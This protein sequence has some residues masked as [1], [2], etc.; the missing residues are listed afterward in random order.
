MMS[1]A[2]PQSP[3]QALQRAAFSVGAL[4]LLLS[5]IGAFLSPERFFPSYLYAWLFAL[6]ITLGSTTLMA[7]HTLVGGLWGLL[8]R[9]WLDA[10]SRAMPLMVLLGLP[11]LFGLPEIF[12]WM[13]GFSRPE[14]AHQAAYLNLPFFLA[15]QALYVLVWLGLSRR[16]RQVL[17]AQEEAPT[18]EGAWRGQKQGALWL[19]CA[20]VTVTFAGIDWVVSLES[21][22]NSSI[23]GFIWMAGQLLAG[24]AAA[25]AGFCWLAPRTPLIR[26]HHLPLRLIDM[27]N[28]LLTAVMV[29]A[30]VAFS[31]LL[32]IW[33]GNLPDEVVWYV[34]RVAGTW[35][36][37][38]VVLG[39]FQFAV[40]FFAL[41]FRGLKRQPRRLG[42]I[43]ALLVLTQ[44]LTM[45]WQVMPSFH[46]GGI[47]PHL[48]DL[49]TLLALGGFLIGETARQL[50]HRPSLLPQD[51][52]LSVEASHA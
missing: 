39:L 37:V 51:E 32:I 13:S 25:I 20:M 36:W 45:Y 19:I 11:L 4:A 2:P 38:A 33:A 27:G 9:P 17:R 31:Q 42:A 3:L 52:R 34:H 28:L 21:G 18:A 8:L 24:L 15:R 35:L 14:L 50:R 6:G 49:A 48:L 46:P 47:R 1:L 23:F 12:P 41:L 5:L 10:S 29:W 7:L 30:Y 44:L 43:A 22:W 40:P 16:L 26:V